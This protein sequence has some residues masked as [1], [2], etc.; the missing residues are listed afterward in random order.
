MRIIFIRIKPET[1]YF[2][3]VKIS[4]FLEDDFITGKSHLIVFFAGREMNIDEFVE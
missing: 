2:G 1:Y 4:I 3:S